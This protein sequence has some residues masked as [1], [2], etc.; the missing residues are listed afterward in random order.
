LGVWLMIGMSGD[1]VQV[2]DRANFVAEWPGLEF[3]IGEGVLM[4][5]WSVMGLHRVWGSLTGNHL[6]NW[7]LRQL[8]LMNLA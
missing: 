2:Q 5:F 8:A 3:G 7:Y 1:S 4:R 6:D